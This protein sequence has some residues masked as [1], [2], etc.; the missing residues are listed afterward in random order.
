MLTF[1]AACG[2][3][4]AASKVTPAACI[5]WTE[6]RLAFPDEEASRP[7]LEWFDAKS[8]AMNEACR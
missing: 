3:G 7:V 2:N 6:M 1:V 4:S 8:A 5:V